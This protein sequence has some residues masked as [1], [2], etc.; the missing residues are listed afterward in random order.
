MDT[1]TMLELFGYLGSAIVIV[2]MLMTSVIK[3]RVI[4]TI[5]SLLFSIYALLIH[6]YPTMAMN[7]VLAGINIYHLI[8]LRNTDRHYDML[9]LSPDKPVMRYLF[10]YFK[11]DIH[12]YFPEFT[13]EAASDCMGYLILCQ[14]SPAGVLLA[15]PKSSSGDSHMDRSPT[16]VPSETLRVVL[17]YTTPKYRDCSV[18]KFL[19]ASLSDLGI[20]TLIAEGSSKPHIK[21]LRKMGFSKGNGNTYI[22]HI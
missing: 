4:N 9:E 2:S 5:G 6:S 13:P 3:L 1:S 22:L 19:Y 8:H 17:D 14:S 18:G 16:D 15:R 20:R 7:L 12:R 21:Y 10:S 11:D